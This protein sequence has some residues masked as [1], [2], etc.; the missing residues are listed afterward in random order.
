MQY[1]LLTCVS[2]KCCEYAP[3]AKCPWRGKC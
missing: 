1:M 3:T 2:K